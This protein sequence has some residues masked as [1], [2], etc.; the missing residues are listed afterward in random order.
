MI[1]SA[2]EVPLAL[3]SIMLTKFLVM[4]AVMWVLENSMN[5]KLFQK[6][7]QYAN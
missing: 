4:Q 2:M 5:Q 6:N 3:A 7:F 1:L